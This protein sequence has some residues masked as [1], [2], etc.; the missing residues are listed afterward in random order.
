MVLPQRAT[1]EDH[2]AVVPSIL[3]AAASRYQRLRAIEKEHLALMARHN[4]LD[5]W[6]DDV[7]AVVLAAREC[8]HEARDAREVFR[9][10]VRTFVVTLRDSGEPIT[11]ALRHVR[12]MIQLLER[13][14]ALT[15]DDGW[16][17][18]EVLEWAIEE[19]EE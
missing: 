9:A 18:A 2:F 4:L 17:E 12:S 16:L 11:A 8:I 14:G 6:S 3:S 13:G 15:N 19:Y 5:E 7:T 1:A 10:Q